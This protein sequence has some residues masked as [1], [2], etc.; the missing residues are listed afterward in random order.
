MGLFVLW[1][2]IILGGLTGGLAGICFWGGIVLI[3]SGIFE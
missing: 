3:V 2:A 1:A